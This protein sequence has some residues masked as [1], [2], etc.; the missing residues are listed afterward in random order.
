MK[1]QQTWQTKKQLNKD[2]KKK[3]KSKDKTINWKRQ[4]RTNLKFNTTQKSIRN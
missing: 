4:I 2:S 3:V 1:N